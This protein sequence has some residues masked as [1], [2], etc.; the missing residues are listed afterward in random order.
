MLARLLHLGGEE[1][2]GFVQLTQPLKHLGQLRRVERL[3]GDFHHRHRIERER[4]ED[5]HR[6]LVAVGGEG[7]GFGE[8]RLHT[9]DECPAAGRHLGHL[10]AVA[11]LVDEEFRDGLGGRVLL[12]VERVRLAQ[13]LD[14]APHLERAAQHAAE[15]V[16]ALAIRSVV[17]LGHVHHQQPLRIAR[18]HV[19]H[20]LLLERSRICMRDLRVRP[21]HRRRQMAHNRVDEPRIRGVEE[22]RHGELQHGLGIQHVLFLLKHDPEVR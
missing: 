14:G 1:R 10:D 18:H 20:K 6:Q 22:A 11:R 15:R 4:P 21:T 2:V 19:V 3:R 12:V 9:L 13:H 8:G 7:A 16:E 17:H 5:A